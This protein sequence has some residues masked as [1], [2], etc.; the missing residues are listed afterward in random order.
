MPPGLTSL[1]V[2]GVN[3]LLGVTARPSAD[4][5][6]ERGPEGK[7]FCKLFVFPLLS[8]SFTIVS[9]SVRSAVMHL[10]YNLIYTT[11]HL[12]RIENQNKK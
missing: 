2:F 8:G 1:K 7:E 3:G 4:A 5:D 9:V 6:F 10:H 11:L 12:H